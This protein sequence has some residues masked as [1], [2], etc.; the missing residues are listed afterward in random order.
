[1]NR[2]T[3]VKNSS[4]SLSALPLLPALHHFKTY[5]IALIGCGWW[6]MNILRE[7]IAYDDCKIKA[8]CDVDVKALLAAKAEVQ[9]LTNDRPEIY[10]DFQDLLD[11]ESIDIAIIGTPDHWHALPAIAA[12]KAGAHLYLEKPIGHT[13]LEGRAILNTARKYGKKVQVGTHRR[14]SPHNI[15][16]MEFLRS[17]MVGE[18]HRVKCFVNY[19]WASAGQKAAIEDIPAGL[20]W[21]RWLGPAPYRAY[22][23]GIHP[24]GF[25]QYLDYANGQIGDWGIHWFDQVLW[26]TEEKYPKSVYSTGNRF[27]REDSTDAPD[28]QLAI[29]QFE[30]FTLDWEHKLFAKNENET[31]NIGC[32]F[33]GTKGTLHLGWLDGWSFYP[34]NK[35][36]QV[37]HQK[38][39]L[40]PPDHQNIK[41]LWADL[42]RAIKKDKLPTCD[43]EKGH[44]A[45]NISHLGMI[46]YK[47]GRSVS[48]DGAAESF[49]E[50]AAANAL[51]KRDYRGEWVYPEV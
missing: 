2:R 29:F 40:H 4:L 16:A 5:K 30:N 26:W 15:T 9:K 8:L 50:D 32:Y 34:R 12:I 25:R 7:A 21:D 44:L 22:I 11:Q 13:I 42:I 33:Y 43:I 51:L 23:P 46:S 14:V 18:V 6:G 31:H 35:K 48:W 49:G 28:S 37:I 19:N 36:A 3:F 24:K 47:L 20:N 45:T 41:E 1:M 39:S 27:V 38:P 17:G 10:E